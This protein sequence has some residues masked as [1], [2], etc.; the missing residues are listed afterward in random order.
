MYRWLSCGRQRGDLFSKESIELLGSFEHRPVTD[1]ID[2][3]CVELS[4][5]P[6]ALY[7]RRPGR[8]RR[9]THAAASHYRTWDRPRN[10]PPATRDATAA[11]AWRTSISSVSVPYRSTRLHFGRRSTP[12]VSA[13]R[14]SRCTPRSRGCHVCGCHGQLACPCTGGQAASG[15]PTEDLR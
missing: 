4:I 10:S 14:Q 2:K 6:V 1:V 3:H 9:T 7:V 13:R 8:T 12:H 5:L 15:T 11:S